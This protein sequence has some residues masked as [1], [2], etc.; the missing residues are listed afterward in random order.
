MLSAVAL[1]H[2][3]GI[4]IRSER[5]AWRRNGIA[6]MGQVGVRGIAEMLILRGISLWV[7]V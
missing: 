3:R 4:R 5:P 2:D 6:R 1:Q 7:H